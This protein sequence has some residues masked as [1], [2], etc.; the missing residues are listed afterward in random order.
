MRSLSIATAHHSL[1]VKPAAAAAFKWQPKAMPEKALV[2]RL[3]EELHFLPAVA[4]FGRSSSATG[5]VCSD[6]NA[7]AMPP[8]LGPLA[9]GCPG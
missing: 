6:S 5:S 4:T 1:M 7:D 8:A 2:G 3:R 9:L